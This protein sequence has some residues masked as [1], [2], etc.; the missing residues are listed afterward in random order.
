MSTARGI[1]IAAILA[2]AGAAGAA[3]PAADLARAG[4]YFR[5]GKAHR[6]D[7]VQTFTPSGF[8]KSRRETGQVVVQEPGNLRFDY[9]E[10]KKTFT[11]DGRVARFYSPAEKQMIVKTLTDEDR[12]ELPLIF[13]EK[14]DEIAQRN[15]LAV[16][17]SGAG[18]TI[19]VTPKDARS[20]VAWI[21]LVLSADGG[22]SGLAFQ[23]SAG[24]RTEFE[25]HG[26]RPEKPLDADA[27][28][29]HPP[30]GTRIVEN[31]P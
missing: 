17:T 28:A 15:T 13:L 24:D 4:A 6:A 23:T 9:A 18:T 5:D 22:P 2:A 10:P 21:R 16:E 8:T 30:A 19:L 27:F 12:A 26:F 7:F 1:V 31:E 3:D 14:A 29:L 25:F 20:D 11:F